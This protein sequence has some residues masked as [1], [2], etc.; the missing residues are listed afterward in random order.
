MKVVATDDDVV[1]VVATDDDVVK[2]TESNLSYDNTKDHCRQ[3][4][5]RNNSCY[6]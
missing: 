5:S 3:C 1:K 4:F 2:A 6:A